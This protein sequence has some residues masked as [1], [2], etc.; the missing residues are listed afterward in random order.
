MVEYFADPAATAATV[1]ED[2]WVRTGDAGY[3]DDDGYLVI[4]DR[5]QDLIIVAGENVYPAEVEKALGAHPD[6]HDCAVVGAP[7]DRWGER[8]HAFV[9]ARPGTGLTTRDLMRF[10]TGRLAGFKVPA[11]YDFVEAIPR[12]PSGKILRRELRERFWADR[13]RRVN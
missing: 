5:V 3:L 11:R 6:V 8:V 7:D 9:V 4:R 12:N 13:D 2:G 10:L 1:T